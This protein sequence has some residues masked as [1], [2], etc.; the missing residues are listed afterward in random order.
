MH[1]T[2]L[3]TSLALLGSSTMLA[4]A[5]SFYAYTCYGCGCNAF[6]GLGT[7]VKE[8]CQNLNQGA[9]AFGIGTEKYSGTYCTLFSEPNCGGESQNV[10]VHSG[11]TWGCTDSNIGWAQSVLCF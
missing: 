7:N 9:A 3:F 5:E 4:Q 6:Q 1:F 2:A 8:S 11:E 10:G